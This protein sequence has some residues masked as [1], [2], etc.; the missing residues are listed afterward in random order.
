METAEKKPEHHNVEDDEETSLAGMEIS[1]QGAEWDER[2]GQFQMMGTIEA[3][4]GM[5]ILSCG[6]WLK[7]FQQESHTMGKR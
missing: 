6:E 4:L 7:G 2:E 3:R 5:R 1:F